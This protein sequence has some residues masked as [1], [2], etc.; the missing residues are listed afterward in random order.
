MSTKIEKKVFRKTYAA[1]LLFVH[2]THIRSAV[3]S[4]EKSRVTKTVRPKSHAVLS[5]FSPSIVQSTHEKSV[6]DISLGIK[7][8]ILKLA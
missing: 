3:F 5:I 8:D 7:Q 6:C 2:F 1:S 4:I